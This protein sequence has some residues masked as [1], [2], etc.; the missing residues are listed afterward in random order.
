MICIAQGIW[1]CWYFLNY[2]TF[3]NFG[4]V[5][6]LL[7]VVVVLPAIRAFSCCFTSTRQHLYCFPWAIL[8]DFVLNCYIGF[9][10]GWNLCF[11][12]SIVSN[13]FLLL[14]DCIVVPIIFGIS[15]IT[16]V[17]FA[18]G[19]FFGWWVSWLGSGLILRFVG[20]EFR[21]LHFLCLLGQVC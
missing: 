16:L 14:G 8:P 21:W 12:A 11:V 9:Y 6:R 7:E 3:C 17:I 20:Q 1:R 18:A 5:Y 10:F 13:F 15:V 4:K 19:F 2:F